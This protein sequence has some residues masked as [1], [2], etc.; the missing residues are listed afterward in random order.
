[1][2]FHE[3]SDSASSNRPKEPA[4]KKVRSR[5]KTYRLKTTVAV[6]YLLF[7]SSSTQK[8][9]RQQDSS[10]VPQISQA[11]ALVVENANDLVAIV[12]TTSMPLWKTLAYK[13]NA[14]MWTQPQLLPISGLICVSVPN[15]AARSSTLPIGILLPRSSCNIVC[16]N[17]SVCLTSE[18]YVTNV[19]EGRLPLNNDQSS[20]CEPIQS[21]ECSQSWRIPITWFQ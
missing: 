8:A 3:R 15:S 4:S 17:I 13:I 2:S 7:R 19:H 18:Y 6:T 1:M 11:G 9:R 12:L 5:N 16:R 14:N 20:I 10:S 21:T